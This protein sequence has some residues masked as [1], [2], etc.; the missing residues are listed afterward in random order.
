[1]RTTKEFAV[2]VFMGALAAA[3]ALQA[4]CSNGPSGPSPAASEPEPSHQDCLARAVFGEPA[5]SNYCLPLPEGTTTLLFQSYCSTEDWSH[6]GRFAYD[7]VCDIGDE[8]LAA[9]DGVVFTIG[10]V[11]PDDDPASGHENRVLIRQAD[12]T[13]AFYA[14][15]QQWSIPVNVGDFVTAGQL[16]GRC[17]SSGTPS[18]PHLHFE[19][20]EGAAYDWDHGVPVNFRN[21]GGP[22]DPRGG[23]E[24][25]VSYV[26]LPCY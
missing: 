12:G 15:F 17:G 21:A 22:F 1:V 2:S 14:H 11:W 7:F 9:Q 24:V 10:E 18:I 26:V 4:A 23:L 5:D 19:V 16:I 20:F 8:I 6:H 25:D 3:V 13:M